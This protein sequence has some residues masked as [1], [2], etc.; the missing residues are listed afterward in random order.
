MDKSTITALVTGSSGLLGRCVVSELSIR[1]DFRVIGT[2]L[3][4]P[5]ANAV[6]LDLT[7]FTA[8][9]GMYMAAPIVS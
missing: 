1:T 9:Q 6:Q 2:F 5:R 7:D 3:S 8:T 4:R